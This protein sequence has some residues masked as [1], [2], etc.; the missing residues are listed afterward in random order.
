MTAI[1]EQ[2][3]RR[4]ATDEDAREPDMLH[5]GVYECDAHDDGEGC[6]ELRGEDA[7]GRVLYRFSDPRRMIVLDEF[8]ATL[9]DLDERYDRIG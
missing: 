9:T 8:D 1:R 5:L 4:R 7:A 2:K 6:F 3:L